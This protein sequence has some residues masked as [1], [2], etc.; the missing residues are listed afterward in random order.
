MRTQEKASLLRS[1]LESSSLPHRSY[2]QAHSKQ[3]ACFPLPPI[4]LMASLPPTM[5][6]LSSH[7]WKENTDVVYISLEAIQVDL[8]TSTF[9]IFHMYS[10]LWSDAKDSST[11]SC[12]GLL[13]YVS[14]RLCFVMHA[15][16]ET[17]N[18]SYSCYT[19]ERY[20]L[21]LISMSQSG[22]MPL[23]CFSLLWILF[24]IEYVRRLYLGSQ[25]FAY[26]FM[27]NYITFSLLFHCSFIAVSFSLLFHCSLDSPSSPSPSSP[28][29]S[30]SVSTFYV[31]FFFVLFCFY[32]QVPL[33]VCC[34]VCVSRQWNLYLFLATA[35]VYLKTNCW[36]LWAWPC[37]VP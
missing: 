17:W 11:L 10:K 13:L 31:F 4:L 35:P 21:M 7:A 5:S 15:G 6:T 36:Q 14:P 16:N 20:S 24:P 2:N 34:T 29:L 9:F 27:W 30:L 23:S 32:G 12:Y 37:V 26:L 19:I 8:S 18:N 22:S 25:S 28:Q 33:W 3:G 1:K